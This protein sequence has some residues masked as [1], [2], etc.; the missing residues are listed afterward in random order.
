MFLHT[1]CDIANKLDK[2]GYYDI[3][4]EVDVII[5]HY[6]MDDVVPKRWNV[7]V[8]KA[9][10][11]EVDKFPNHIRGRVDEFIADLEKNGPRINPP[12]TYTWSNFSKLHTGEY[13][14]HIKNGRPTYIATWRLIS[15]PER[16]IQVEFIGTHEK[17]PYQ[18]R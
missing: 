17:S 3:A 6:A 5:R 15:S 13:H 4:N 2:L 18:K 8:S 1:L 7:H 12:G 16:V 14:C 10:R 11:K 9:I